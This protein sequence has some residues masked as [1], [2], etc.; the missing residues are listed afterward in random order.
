MKSSL[1]L[2]LIAIAAAGCSTAEAQTESADKAPMTPPPAANA[3]RV[4]LATVQPSEANLELSLPGEVEGS[5]DASLASPIGGLVEQV[6]VSPGDHVRRGQTLVAVDT[7]AQAARRAEARVE[8]EAAAREHHRYEQL[9]DAIARVELD[10][11]RTRLKAAR[12][13]NKTADIM[14]AR[15]IVA[16]SFDGVV[17]SVDVELGEVA[18]PGAPLVRVVKLDPA[19]VTVS[20]SE[21]DVGALQEGMPATVTTPARAGLILEG[22]VKHI[23]RAADLKTRT[24]LAEVEVDN[25]E[26]RL[27]PGMIATVKLASAVDGTGLVLRQDWL[28]TRGQEVGVFVDHDGVAQW[29]RVKLGPVTGDQVVVRSGIEA[30]EALVV[31]GHRQLADGDG[32]LVARQGRCCVDGRVVFD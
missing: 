20:L 32:L 27:L 21:R 8:L 15:S 24:F 6:L 23:Q 1:L 11:A 4:E 30:G 25:P 12:A 13:A 5:R 17:V 29:R 9:G 14:V 26:E 7:T 2:L 3:I 22:R 16:A 19:L 18:A 28:V 31:T 10:S